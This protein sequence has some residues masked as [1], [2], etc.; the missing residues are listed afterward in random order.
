MA[1]NPYGKFVAIY[2][3]MAWTVASQIV[4]RVDASWAGVIIYLA[5]MGVAIT[6]WTKWRG[7]S[8]EHAD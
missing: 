4:M 8:D 3:G 5:F 6:L 7:G 2:F 1:E